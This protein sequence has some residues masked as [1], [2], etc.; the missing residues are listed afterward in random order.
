MRGPLL[1]GGK[2]KHVIVVVQENRTV[3]NLFQGFPGADT[4]SFGVSRGQK[5][6][7]FRCRSNTL[8]IRIMAIPASSP[9]MTAARWTASITRTTRKHA[10]KRCLNARPTRTCD[11]PTRP[12]ISR[13]RS[14]MR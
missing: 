6:T 4:V 1:G 14:N 11:R 13:S 7:L 3:D 10:T 2:I 12:A 8:S 9:T 5:K